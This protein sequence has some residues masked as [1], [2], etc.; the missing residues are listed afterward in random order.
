MK[1]VTRVLGAICFFA[2]TTHAGSFRWDRARDP[3]MTKIVRALTAAIDARTPKDIPLDSLPG[4]PTF[5]SLLALRSAT[6]LELAGGSELK[7][8]AVWYFLGHALVEADRGRDDDAL[9]LLRRALAAAPDAPEATQAWLDIAT[10]SNRS[11][12]FEAERLAYVEALRLQWD[13]NERATS[14]MNR[15]EASASLGDL[16]HARQDYETALA[17]TDDSEIHTLATWDLAVDLARDDDLPE[18]LA[19]AWKASQIQFH[20][21]QGNPISALELPTVYFTP[22]YEIF[23]Y[24][25][26]GAMGVSEHAENAKDRRAELEWAVTQWLRFLAEGRAQGDRYVAN[27]AY[28]LEWCRRRLGKK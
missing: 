9:A 27:A 23:Y 26:L 11:L 10:A 6:V 4:M 2:T 3:E 12:D 17:I 18:A 19:Y 5:R 1:P 13:R 7:S 20:D 15:G 28:Q 8:P 21:Q 22:A 16:G 24:R 14:Y 25:A